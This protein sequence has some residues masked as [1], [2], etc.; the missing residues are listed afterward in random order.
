MAAVSP[1]EVEKHLKGV[2]YP[3]KKTDLIKKARQEGA[4]EQIIEALQQMPGEVFNKP[5]DVT[6]AIGQEDRGSRH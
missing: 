3:A 6:K 4:N 1:K 2:D 5:T